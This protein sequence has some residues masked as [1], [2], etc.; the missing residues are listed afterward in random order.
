MPQP[1]TY[2]R[3]Y[4]ATDWSTLNP[5][6]PQPGVSLD[7]EFNAVGTT[8]AAVLRNLALIQR[9]DGALKN[10]I[11][12]ADALSAAVL[13]LFG[14]SASWIP[15]GAWVTA[16]AYAV[17]DVVSNGTATYVAASAHT[18]G[19]FAT[20]LAAGRWVLIFDSAGSIPADVSVTTAKIADGAVTG[21]K[22]GFTA[23]DLIG[24]LRGQAGVAAG[25][26]TVA[27]ASPFRAKKDTGNVYVDV[28]R[29][30]DAQGVAAFRS[31]GVTRTWTLGQQT[32]VS[33]FT[34]N[35]GAGAL[36]TWFST[37]QLDQAGTFRST[38]ATSPASGSGAE[39]LFSAGAGYFQAYN[40]DTNAFLP[41]YLAGLTATLSAGG[42]DILTATSTT[43]DFSVAP[44]VGGVELGY[45]DAPQNVQNGAYTLA[46]ADRGRHI[47]SE[48]VA[49]Q[50][51][52]IPVN[53]TVALP[54]G[55]AI[56]V[57][58]NGT[59]PITLSPAGGV[60]LKRAGTGATGSRTLAANGMA[61]L[62]KTGTNAWFLS[63]AG[64]S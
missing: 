40:R 4:S 52:T 27:S 14:A 47:Y 15:R 8:L 45:R 53:A 12:T 5:S 58:N 31:I 13:L 64:I 16:T 51:V 18:A 48:N 2:S 25:T 23:L 24:A 56:V 43:A 61:T 62:L 34:L 6:T 54:V 9:D 30:T 49:G 1:P 42:V 28:E 35:A 17:S 33:T 37:G 32:G 11:V 10:G 55:S 7:A 39:V 46:L 44:S 63:G 19:V 57:V 21:P 60:T 26:A 3:Q 22:V 36:S 59:N 50:T 38:A 20:D 41:V 29:Q